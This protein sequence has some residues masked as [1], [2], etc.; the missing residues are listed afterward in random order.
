M[1]C[2]LLSLAWF[3]KH[4]E[5]SAVKDELEWA[6]G[7]RRGENVP[8]SEAAAQCASIYLGMGSFDGEGRHIDSE[9]IETAFGHPNCIGTSACANLKRRARPDR[10]RR[11]ELDKQRFWLPSVPRQ[12]SRGVALIP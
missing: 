6:A 5:A 2:E 4:M 8:C 3:I 10:V 1:C 9:Y 12:L 7:R 11:E